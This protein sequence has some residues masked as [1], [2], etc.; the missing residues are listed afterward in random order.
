M[1]YL[2]GKISD[3]GIESLSASQALKELLRRERLSREDRV[4]T[5]WVSVMMV[6]VFLVLVLFLIHVSISTPK[7]RHPT[8]SAWYCHTLPLVNILSGDR[9]GSILLPTCHT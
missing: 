2:A 9:P 8:E 3:E 4:S 6:M 7:N 5:W 1:A